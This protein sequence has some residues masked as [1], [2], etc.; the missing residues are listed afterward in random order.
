[1]KKVALLI[2]LVVNCACFTIYSQTSGDRFAFTTIGAIPPNDNSFGSGYS[3]YASVWPLFENYP[4]TELFQTGLVS[5]WMT[6]QPTG[7]EPSDGFYNT[8][9]GGLGWWTGLRF[10]HTAPKFIMGGVS[11]DFYSWANGPGAGRA[12]T[13]DGFR[14]WSE[15]NGML[16]VAQLA[17]GVLW[18]PD[19]L[20]MALDNKGDF[21]GYGYLS[22]PL[23]DTMATTR[24]Q[25]IA[26]GNH[27][28]TLF[29]NTENFKGPVAFFLPTFWTKPVLEDPSLEG[30]FLDSRP[31]QPVSSFGIETATLPMVHA[32]DNNGKK[33]S[34]VQP[35][36]YPMSGSDESLLLNRPM[37]YSKAA[38][39]T[40]VQDW[41]NGG[42]MAQPTL[43]MQGQLE[44]LFDTNDDDGAAFF[45]SR[46]KLNPGGE[47]EDDE[48][49]IESSYMRPFVKDSHTWG[50]KM[51]TDVVQVTEGIF[52]TP[53]YFELEDNSLQ[54]NPINEEN[55]PAET[56]LVSYEFET[57][58]E[59]PIPLLTPL[60]VDCPWHDPNGA[61]LNPGPAAGPFKV[62]LEDGSTL[63]YYW[64]RFVDQPA[65]I[66]ANLT[67]DQRQLLQ[68][69][70]ELIH[71]NW[72]KTDT[73]L[74]DPT[75][76]T[77][78]SLDA[79]LVVQPPVGLEIGYVPIVTRQEKTVSTLIAE[80]DAEE[81]DKNLEFVIYPNPSESNFYFSEA[82]D[83]IEIF[84][85]S[86]RRVLSAKS[87]PNVD[88]S[89]LSQGVYIVKSHLQ[90]GTL[91][92]RKIIK[93]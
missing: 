19:G 83:S 56:G 64:Y 89:A 49:I 17:N 84:S 78:A 24:G 15:P 93:D 79:G 76:G 60:E 48:Y 33:I 14:N 50:Y 11:N 61:W 30:L 10:G 39:W 53:E 85:L 51:A 16:D 3:I 68:E 6:P 21:L 25:N 26:T 92:T 5:V 66:S 87:V 74:P 43:S 8:I 4:K 72:K 18:P 62:D 31:S 42:A 44:I 27:S 65:V 90:N 37:V 20:N 55:V 67:N 54:G 70:I 47:R 40:K 38:I 34:K 45:D 71:T 2:M 69:R 57:N 58:I 1:M 75:F 36:R 12:D 35:T 9:E 88:I 59:E 7:N 82:I 23:T 91:K 52:K 13:E 73:Y 32:V 63:T 41:F 28:W 29:L 86:G 22:L 81:N 46:I 77:L 80:E